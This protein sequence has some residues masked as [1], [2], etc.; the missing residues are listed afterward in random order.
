MPSSKPVLF[1]KSNILIGNLYFLLCLKCKGT[2]YLKTTEHGKLNKE[3]SVKYLIKFMLLMSPRVWCGFS[4]PK[5]VWLKIILI[6]SY[7]FV[8]DSLLMFISETFFFE[9]NVAGVTL[10]GRRA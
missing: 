4:P 8:I 9:K 3:L 2:I 5:T 6:L 10:T 1:K 7:V